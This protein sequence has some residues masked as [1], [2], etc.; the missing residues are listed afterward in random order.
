MIGCAAWKKFER[1]EF[2]DLS[3]RAYASLSLT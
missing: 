2:A 3:E 1:G